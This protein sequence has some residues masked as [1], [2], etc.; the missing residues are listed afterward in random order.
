MSRFALVLGLILDRCVVDKTGLPG[1]FDLDIHF[2][3]DTQ[4]IQIG[5]GQDPDSQP[6]SVSHN[7]SISAALRQQL[8]LRLVPAKDPVEL[9]F[10]EHAER[11]SAN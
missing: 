11:P 8:G 3:V 6:A 2:A 5:G 10:I 4:R 7:P 9:L 1:R